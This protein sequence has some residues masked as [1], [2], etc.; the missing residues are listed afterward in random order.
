MIDQL[1]QSVQQAAQGLAGTVGE[2]AKVKTNQ[3]IEDWLKIFPRLE[4]YGLEITSFS[5][6]LAI[7]PSLEVELVG[8]HEDWTMDRL[9]SLLAENKGNPAMS[10]VLTTIKSAYRLHA[11]SLATL[12]PPLI[13]KVSIRLSPEVRVVLGQPVLERGED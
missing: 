2:G 1:W 5:L 12:R 11:K 7:S 6:G 3:L 10:M 9:D 4:I 13:L 8:N